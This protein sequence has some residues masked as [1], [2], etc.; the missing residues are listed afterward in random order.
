MEEWKGRCVSVPGH[1]M[2][3]ADADRQKRRGAVEVAMLT[4]GHADL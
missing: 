2:S 1:R 4:L 3:S